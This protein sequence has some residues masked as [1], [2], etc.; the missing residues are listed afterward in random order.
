V[1]LRLAIATL[2][3]TGVVFLAPVA[4]HADNTCPAPGGSC[5]PPSQQI[6]ATG[7]FV[8]PEV[9][10]TQVTRAA[11]ATPNSSLPLTGGD[12]A[13]L[14]LIGVVLVAGGAILVHRTR[15]LTPRVEAAPAPFAG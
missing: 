5:A 14:T 10:A 11:P 7:G 1:K 2:I 9:Q 8:E 13:G 6:V 15:K 3:A 12:V 4:A